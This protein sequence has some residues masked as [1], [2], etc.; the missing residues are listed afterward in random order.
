PGAYPCAAGRPGQSRH[1]RRR[2]GV[3]GATSPPPFPG[4][5]ST[6]PHPAFGCGAVLGASENVQ[7]GSGL[8]ALRVLRLGGR[9]LLSGALSGSG[10]LLGRL[11]GV[12][13]VAG[14][15]GALAVL[16]PD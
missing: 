15:L 9:G 13:G 3:P 14:A 10:L 2:A 8:L 11:P 7:D 1:L 16:G 12:R 6:A 4:A 5:Q